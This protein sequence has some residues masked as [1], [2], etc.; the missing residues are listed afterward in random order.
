MEIFL[1]ITF[2]SL[3]ASAFIAIIAI[4]F[5]LIF[6]V[7]KFINMAHGSFAAVGAYGVYTLSTLYGVNI[8][9]AI[10]LGIIGAGLCALIIDKI[11]FLPLRNR[12]ATPMVQLIA[13]LGAFTVIQA[14]L[15][16][17]YTS[18]FQMIATGS[19][20]N[21]VYTFGSGVLTTVQLLAII[22]AIVC[23]IIVL[24]FLK[25]TQFGRSVRAVSDDEE[26]SK[27]IGINTNR[28][29]SWTFFIGGALAGLGGI[30][31]G[32]D[33]GI[34]PI[35]GLGLL[36]G[37]VV[38]C[39]I[40]GRGSVAGAVLGALLLGFAENFGIWKI[41]GEWKFAMSFG[42]LIVFLLFRPDG[43]LKK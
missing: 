40:G 22:S 4:G 27:I 25:T 39:I 36:L 41:A 1:Q 13:S 26:V 18:Q 28:T 3:V 32:M 20:V 10:A 38:A 17:T 5:N 2:N 15:A 34:E 42:L 30:L 9:L 6:G 35:M 8:W 29:I 19:F 43:I 24:L 11:L 14:L 21:S 7:T 31:F 23:A 33:T 37:P 16:I 12:K